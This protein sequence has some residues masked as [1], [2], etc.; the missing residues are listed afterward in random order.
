MQLR[1]WDAEHSSYLFRHRPERQCRFTALY[2]LLFFSFAQV[3]A[4]FFHPPSSQPIEQ[5]CLFGLLYLFIFLSLLPLAFICPPHHMNTLVLFLG[6]AE[7]FSSIKV[8]SCS[9]A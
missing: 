8:A 2:Q 5:R 7:P 3:F 1:A 9:A 6:P 4:I